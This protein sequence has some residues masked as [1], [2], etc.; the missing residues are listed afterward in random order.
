MKD[1]LSPYPAACEQPPQHMDRW[2]RTQRLY[3]HLVGLGL[4]VEAIYSTE[5]QGG[6]EYLKVS[7]SPPRQV[8]DHG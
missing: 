7:V 4:W 6:I 1:N 5:R 2:A 8:Q 3:E